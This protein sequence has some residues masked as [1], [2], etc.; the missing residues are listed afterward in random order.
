MSD[1]TA[2][3][4]L[5]TLLRQ[6]LAADPNPWYPKEYAQ[7]NG[8]DREALFG[9]LN[10][11]RIAN[12][13][14]LTDW[15]KSK[16][17]GYVITGLGREVL[18]DA[19]SLARLREGKS[20]APAAP[21][22]VAESSAG[23]SRFERGEI[24]RRAF[25]LPGTVRVVPVLIGLNLLGFMI[26]FAIAIRT[27][28]DPMKFIGQ[29]DVIALQKSGAAGAPELAEG[30]WWRL[31]TSCFLHFGIFHLGVNMLTLA[32]VRRVELLWGSGRFLVLYLICGVCGS[33]VGVYCNPGEV[34]RPMYLAGASGALWGVMASQVGWLVF[35]YSHLPANEVRQWVQH[36]IFIFLLNM[37]VSMAPGVS[38]EAHLGGGAAGLL[39]AGLLQAH[40]FGTPA[41][42]SLAGLLLALL[43]S[44]FLLGLSLGLEHDPRLQPF[45]SNVYREGLDERLGRLAPAL[46]GLEP[47]AE[48]LIAQESAKRDQAEVA[49]VREGLQGLVKQGRESAEWTQK[50]ATGS[51]ARAPRERGVAL[52][53]TLAAYAE[54]LDKQLGGEAV[55]NLAELR[56]NWLEAKANW[57]KLGNR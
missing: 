35:N 1:A 57:A 47:T 8:M 46:A 20:L 45:L 33:C 11:L 9:P 7:T 24:A 10:D 28:V 56:Q 16:G 3:S 54:G 50:V 31:L 4:V 38:M 5:E 39:A 17:Q 25:F 13:V 6:I 55:P 22:P 15:I 21:E 53:E 34:T 30:E 18:N 26:S 12:L 40:R 44:L 36:L 49:R 32:L 43:P 41:R 52:A 51:A 42:R 29:G 23:A 19:G 27:G 14:Q 37:G 2:T 48:R